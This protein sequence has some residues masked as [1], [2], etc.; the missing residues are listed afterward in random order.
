MALDSLNSLYAYYSP[1]SLYGI[2]NTA[3]TSSISSVTRLGRSGGEDAGGTAVGSITSVSSLGSALSA[4]SNLQS[5]AEKLTDAGAFGALSVTSS[6]P[7]VARGSAADGTAQGSY[8]VRVDQLAQE[9]VLTSAAQGSQYGTI[10][11]GISTTVTFQFAS[12]ESAQVQI[13]GSNNTLRGIAN[14][15]NSAG[16][17][18]SA[19]IISNAS[20]Y[21]LQIVG[22]SG[23]ANAFSVNAAGDATL[24]DFLSSPPGGGGL[25]R[26]QQAQDAQGTVN[27]V[28]FTSSTNTA[29]T[30]VSGLTLN[31]KETGNATLSVGT[32]PDQA[33]AVSDFVDAYNAVQKS[34]TGL[35]QSYPGFSLTAP[36]LRSSL[37]GALNPGEEAGSA[38]ISGLDDLGISRQPSGALSLD[39]GRLKASLGQDASAVASLFSNSEGTGIADQILQKVGEGGS[40]STERL[41]QVVSPSLSSYGLSSSLSG[42]YGEQQNLLSQYGSLGSLSVSLASTSSLLSSLLGSSSNNLSGLGLIGGLS[43]PATVT[44]LFSS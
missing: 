19:S 40:L 44:S 13:D 39:T 42:I 43:N 34:L 27:G 3:A 12:G 15:V 8:R 10:G 25:L 5:A 7:A 2:G 9:Q 41:L 21:Q 30:A 37:A 36:F 22:A 14:A 31:L 18:L 38:A 6:A 35:A 4:V 24:E 20:G 1:Y 29:S 11:S 28:A 26:T 16:N 17:G 32:N 33:K 23:A